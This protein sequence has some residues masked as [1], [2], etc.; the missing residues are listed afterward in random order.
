LNGVLLDTGYLITFSDPNRPNH[1][2]A[3]AYF[4]EF[5]Q[6]G[7]TM[8]LSVIVASEFQVRQAITDLPL[9][10]FLIAP[11][12]I[13]DAIEC[14]N[15]AKLVMASRDKSDNRVCLKDDLKLIA[16]CKNQGISHFICEDEKL[17]AKYAKKLKNAGRAPG[18]PEIILLSSG[19]DAA[20]FN[21]GQTP[22]DYGPNLP[23][24]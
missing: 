7:W 10:S 23:S 13:D 22:I 8:Y 2:V 17:A 5:K 4:K 3:D 18:L 14:G 19:F 16:Q 21:N 1:A 24:A 15:L 20:I 11:F 9:N 12:N 6:R